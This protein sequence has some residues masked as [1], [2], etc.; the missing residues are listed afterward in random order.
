MRSPGDPAAA[1]DRPMSPPDAAGPSAGPGFTVQIDGF[2]VRKLPD[3]HHRRAEDGRY[4]LYGPAGE[5]VAT[6]VT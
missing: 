1:Y 2:T 4:S 6:G 3:P 5:E